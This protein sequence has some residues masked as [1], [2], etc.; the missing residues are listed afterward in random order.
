ML[1]LL[2]MM[3]VRELVQKKIKENKASAGKPLVY[4]P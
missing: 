4:W 1:T 3:L 2:A